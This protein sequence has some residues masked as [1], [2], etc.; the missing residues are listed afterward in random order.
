MIKLKDY[1][2]VLEG[3]SSLVL[4]VAF[5][6]MIVHGTK[7]VGL[8]VIQFTGLGVL[9]FTLMRIKPIL[10]S[11]DEKDYVLVMFVEL[12]IAVIVGVILLFFPESAK[13]SKSIISF[14]RLI[15][16]VLFVRGICHFWTTA[17]RYEL[18]DIISFIMHIVFISFGFLYLYTNSLKQG[19]I[20]IALMILSI[21]LS[22]YFGYRSY[23]G[24]NRYR[25]QKGNIQKMGDYLGK[26]NEKVIE[27]P[28]TI[29]EKINPE[30]IDE[31]ID[32][33]RP[34]ADIN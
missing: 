14:S 4:L 19:K 9:F 32:D 24:Y 20:V 10:S 29:E 1:N 8:L 18:H 25:I 23:N 3:L 21:L 17:K 7:E 27:D 15:G 6:L 30:I 2:W 26:K 33:N 13:D 34:S 16:L 12:L 31:P 5:I 11:R 22:I 28:K